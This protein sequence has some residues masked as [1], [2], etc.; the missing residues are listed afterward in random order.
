[1]YRAKW[2]RRMEKK[3]ERDRGR[4]IIIKTVFQPTPQV[5]AAIFLSGATSIISGDTAC[6]MSE[7]SNGEEKIYLKSSQLRTGVASGLMFKV[8]SHKFQDRCK[9]KRNSAVNCFCW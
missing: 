8:L 5:F 4:I 2:Q 3:I 6:E 1:M 9:S 7:Y